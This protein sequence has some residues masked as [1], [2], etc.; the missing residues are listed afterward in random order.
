LSFK[1]KNITF[2]LFKRKVFLCLFAIKYQTLYIL[3]PER[4]IEFKR[5]YPNT[6]MPCIITV[7]EIKNIGDNYHA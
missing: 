4:K 7:A 3:Y 1:Y 2:Q 6:R 5:K